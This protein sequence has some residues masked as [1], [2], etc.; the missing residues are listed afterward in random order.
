MGDHGLTVVETQYE[1]LALATHLVD[2]PTSQPGND[3]IGG[4]VVTGG[5]DVRHLHIFEDTAK[6][7]RLEVASGQL[8]FRKFRQAHS[9]RG[10]LADRQET[11]TV[12]TP[13]VIH[14]RQFGQVLNDAMVGLGAVWKT[15][16]WPAVI[17]FIPVSLITVWVFSVTG[18]ADFLE[19][20]L[21]TPGSLQTLPEQVIAE[22]AAPLFWAAGIASLLQLLAAVFVALASHAA[23][24]AHIKGQP[25]TSGE[26]TRQALRRYPT[27]VGATLLIAIVVLVLVVLGIVI[28]LGPMTS[29]GTPN[30]ASVLVALLLLVVLVGP[31]LWVAVATSMTTST[32]TIESARALDS[33]RRSMRLVR[34]RWW[35]TAGYLI[36]VGLLGGIAIQL[37]QL[38]ALPLALVGGGGSALGIASILGVL[39]QGVLI[40]GIAA[41]YTH[42]YIDLR[43]RREELSSESLG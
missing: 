30:D 3:L 12:T 15:L 6:Q 10:C 36:L 38:V 25:L 33:I 8:D 40:A 5:P 16:L 2:T 26:A 14:P 31:G 7:R 34:G 29:V 35:P 24:A 21:N 39:A 20:L 28:W 1:E 4:G 27:G 41:M 17:V 32:V 19:T 13:M 43:A 9:E 11:S 23:V 18:A 22:M 42:W 37:I